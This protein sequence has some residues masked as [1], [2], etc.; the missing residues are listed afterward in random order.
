MS[1]EIDVLTLILDNDAGMYNRVTKAAIDGVKNGMSTGSTAEMYRQMLLTGRG[2]AAHADYVQVVGLYVADAIDEWL[3][4]VELPAPWGDYLTTILA[5]SSGDVKWELGD[6]YMPE[7]GDW[8]NEWIAEE[9][10]DGDDDVPDE[11]SG[12]PLADPTG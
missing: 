4:E 1:R 10:D 7:D 6:H 5:L 8:L 11:G 2:D 3:Q 9:S 12:Y